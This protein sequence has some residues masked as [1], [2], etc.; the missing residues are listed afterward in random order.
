MRFK[1]LLFFVFL[2][3]IVPKAGRAA[4][5][6][7]IVSLKPNITSILGWLGVE[8]R[9]VGVTKFCPFPSGKAQ[10]V[11]DYTSVDLEALVKLK[12]DLILASHENSQ[13][14]Q[15][16]ALLAQGFNIKFF[17]F[18]NFDAMTKSFAEI[19]RLV[20]QEQEAF[21]IQSEMDKTIA[22]NKEKITPQNF[23]VVVQH[24]PLMVAGGGTFISTLF[25]KFGLINSFQNNKINYPVIDEETLLRASPDI[26]FDLTHSGN[27]EFK[28]GTAKVVRLNIEDFLAAPKSISE[29]AKL[30]TG[31]KL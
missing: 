7:H 21:T 31:G 20:N 10:I 29:V 1:S 11:A 22:R 19:S 2:C 24:K 15:Y 30:V 14:R 17:D 25:A 16:E 6:Q 4:D 13:G 23:V 8:E 18:S 28:L 26:I 27:E 3:I 5:Y 12:P 9:V